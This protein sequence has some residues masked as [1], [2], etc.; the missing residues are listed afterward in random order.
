M[1]NWRRHILRGVLASL[2]IT[3]VAGVTA[4]LF[5]SGV[6]WRLTGAG[7]VTAVA[8]LLV[9]WLT[10]MADRS[11]DR[12]GALVGVVAVGVEY[13]L[14]LMLLWDV[15]VA[16]PGRWD[17]TELLATAGVLPVATV[18]AMI[19]LK[20][21]RKAGGRI[22]AYTGLAATGAALLSALIAIWVPQGGRSQIA[23]DFWLMAVAVGGLG[24]LG[25]GALHGLGA[26][27]RHWRWVGVAATLVAAVMATVGIWSHRNSGGEHLNLVVTIAFCVAA[28]NILCRIELR[29]HQQWLRWST[30]GTGALAAG[31]WVAIAYGARADEMIRLCAASAI[32]ATF[33]G[34]ALAV[35]ERLN[36][37]GVESMP[38]EMQTITVFCPRCRKKQTLQLGADTC[39][40]CQL[41]IE[42]KAQEPSCEKC[43]YLLYKLTSDRCPECGEPIATPAAA[44]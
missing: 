33:G 28:A 16:L 30:L 10:S 27:R 36:R 42:V 35:L 13:V 19:F 3:A 14:F 7:L 44:A 25:A 43:G 21:F 6:V 18:S 20:M 39:K 41:Q 9:L 34:L 12:P 11:P 2:A 26:D 32:P 4:V 40:A 31:L 8:C 24:L 15:H 5:S 22:A 37:R 17:E 38:R 1:S 23:T 29:P